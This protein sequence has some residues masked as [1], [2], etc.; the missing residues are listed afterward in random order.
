MHAPPG[1]PRWGRVWRHALGWALF[2]ALGFTVSLA[3]EIDPAHTRLQTFITV[4]SDIATSMP[5]AYASAAW[6]QRRQSLLVAVAGWL[7]FAGGWALM[8]YQA[9]RLT[10]PDL[11]PWEPVID[12]LLISSFSVLLQAGWTAHRTRQRLRQMQA[13]REQTEQRL[14][15]SQLAPHV[16]Y[17]LINGLYAAALT[18]PERVAPQVQELLS[19]VNYLTQAAS[20]DF[21]PA[22]DEWA[23]IQS[24]ANLAQDRAGGLAEISLEFEGDPSC[25]VPALL[26][27]TLFENAVKHGTDGDGRLHVQAVLRGQAGGLECLVRNRMPQGMPEPGG[28]RLGLELVRQRLAVLYGERHRLDVLRSANHF[29]VRLLTW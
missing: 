17:N 25:P 13:L 27:V 19:M 26:L 15:S 23:F 8:A 11:S 16:L 9:Q 29:E 1:T 5:L 14:F 2:T 7:V 12:A 3:L 20:R 6:A 22:G 28:L 10:R 21:S 18:Q 4:V 24:H